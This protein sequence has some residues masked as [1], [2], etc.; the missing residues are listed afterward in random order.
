MVKRLLAFAV[1]VAFAPC[2]FSGEP[3]PEILA[4]KLMSVWESGDVEQLESFMSPDVLYEDLA[5]G[6]SLD[7]I[8]ATS[9]YI[10]HVHTWASGVSIEVTRVFG[11]D[12]EAAAVWVMT[13]IQSGPIPGRV[14]IATNRPIEVHGITLVTIEDGKISRATDSLDALGFVLQLGATVDLPGGVRLPPE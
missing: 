5:N 2:A 13:A 9:A 11:N 3:S 14:P 8:A 4:K 7:G 10:S 6:R 12:S 1:A